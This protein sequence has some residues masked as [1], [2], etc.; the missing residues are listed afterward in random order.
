MMSWL[1][2]MIGTACAHAH[3]ARNALWH[4]SAQ[5]NTIYH[6][7]VSLSCRGMRPSLATGHQFAAA[8]SI[9]KTRACTVDISKHRRP[10]GGPPALLASDPTLCA[11]VYLLHEHRFRR[12]FVQVHA[13]A[14]VCTDTCMS[15]SVVATRSLRGLLPTLANAL[16]HAFIW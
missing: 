13:Q 3:E 7:P 8:D 6:Y 16:I 2:T 15:D 10:R 14:R 4:G 5:D 9:G 12:G 1:G 11:R